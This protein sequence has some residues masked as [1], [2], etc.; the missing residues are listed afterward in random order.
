METAP[1]ELRKDV[2]ELFAKINRLNVNSPVALS[3]YNEVILR[4]IQKF[5]RQEKF[6]SDLQIFKNLSEYII[7]SQKTIQDRLNNEPVH[8]TINYDKWNNYKIRIDNYN[9]N[10]GRLL[11]DGMI[12]NYEFYP[13]NEFYYN[14]EGSLKTISIL[15]FT[16]A[17][18]EGFWQSIEYVLAVFELQD[19]DKERLSVRVQLLMKNVDSVIFSKKERQQISLMREKLKSSIHLKQ[20]NKNTKLNKQ[21]KLRYKHKDNLNKKDSRIQTKDSTYAP[22]N[23]EIL[24]YLDIIDMHMTDYLDLTLISDISE[25]SEISNSEAADNELD[26]LGYDVNN[27]Y[28]ENITLA[29]IHNITNIPTISS[30]KEDKFKYRPSNSE[31]LYLFEQSLDVQD[32]YDLKRVSLHTDTLKDVNV[33]FSEKNTYTTNSLYEMLLYKEKILAMNATNAEINLEATLN[34]YFDAGIEKLIQDTYDQGD[35][36]LAMV[37]DLFRMITY[38]IGNVIVSENVVG[39]IPETN[40][41]YRSDVLPFRSHDN[42]T[43]KSFANGESGT[44]YHFQVLGNPTPPITACRV[45]ER[46]IYTEGQFEQSFFKKVAEDDDWLIIFKIEIIRG[47]K[48]VYE[49]TDS[50]SERTYYIEK[51]KAINRTEGYAEL[52]FSVRC[53]DANGQIV[54]SEVPNAEMTYYVSQV[55][56]LSKQSAGQGTLNSLN[57][58]CKISYVDQVEV[59][60]F[61]EADALEGQVEFDGRLYHGFIISSPFNVTKLMNEKVK[62]N[63]TKDLNQTISDL[64]PNPQAKTYDMNIGI[65]NSKINVSSDL[66][67]S[68]IWTGLYTSTL[69]MKENDLRNIYLLTDISSYTDPITGKPWNTAINSLLPARTVTG[70]AYTLSVVMDIDA[71]IPMPPRPN[72][73]P[74]VISEFQ[75]TTTLMLRTIISDLEDM[76]N[77]ITTLEDFAEMLAAEREKDN[78]LGLGIFLDFIS[79]VPLVGD[80]IVTSASVIQ[81]VNKVARDGIAYNARV[82]K[83]LFSKNEATPIYDKSTLDVSSSGKKYRIFDNNLAKNGKTRADIDSGSN[84]PCFKNGSEKE[85]H[86]DPGEKMDLMTLHRTSG[87]YSLQGMTENDVLKRPLLRNRGFHPDMAEGLHIA[88]RPLAVGSEKINKVIFDNF[89]KKDLK[90][91]FNR[92]DN[93]TEINT[94]KY[95]HSY[96]YYNDY[97]VDGGD[98][99]MKRTYI[100]VGELNMFNNSTGDLNAQMG[101]IQYL[102]QL[103]GYDKQ[104]GIPIYENLPRS[105][106]DYTDLEISNFYKSLF[107]KEPGIIPV[108]SQW[109]TI[110]YHLEK[111]RINN[112]P[113]GWSY[114]PDSSVSDMLL[115]MLKNP[116]GK[117][118]LLNNNCQSQLVELINFMH[119]G[120]LPVGWH[121]NDTMKFL[122]S[123]LNS[124][125]QRMGDLLYSLLS[126]S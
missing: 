27:I 111:T 124:Q 76:K 36:T 4:M 121:P 89:T 95:A 122:Q 23:E 90:P 112:N 57:L 62:L 92:K 78:Q 123:Y 83:T 104:T 24:I 73:I 55:C 106:S 20:K 8:P 119:S 96:A 101:G 125:T 65:P 72:N 120:Q 61:T 46:F 82:S 117:Y 88:Y 93:R 19:Q 35:T 113:P 26:L 50:S 38:I 54:L 99:F 3:Q 64:L 40:I 118:N 59:K 116:T 33:Q 114:I 105:S 109:E 74:M 42:T 100:G 91:I 10:D 81:D 34:A 85:Q 70:Q 25:Q 15:K 48:T 53:H 39:A 37:L 102:K 31:V 75:N 94:R 97:Y 79:L 44:G 2:D 1:D 68:N 7:E 52:D 51:N 87:M 60:T 67:V 108:D 115:E 18:K 6:E 32:L 5:L 103:K 14:D 41:S 11:S 63:I 126:Q 110:I 107:K 69:D 29:L 17:L 45:T 80:V 47:D 16:N 43:F 66:P 84:R 49:A 12:F 28:R 9:D 58:V 13:N 86:Y 98:H 22:R 21:N 71:E 77:R 30:I 56:V